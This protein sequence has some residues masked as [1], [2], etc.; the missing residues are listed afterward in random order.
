MLSPNCIQ[1]IGALCDNNSDGVR[2]GDIVGNAV[3]DN[4]DEG[5]SIG[6]EVGVSVGNV[7]GI[8]SVVVGA[9]VDFVVSNSC[10]STNVLSS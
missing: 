4:D 1:E 5:I 7:E 3:D 8:D 9:N 10:G 2:V 6:T